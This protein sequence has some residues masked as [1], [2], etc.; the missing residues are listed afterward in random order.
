MYELIFPAQQI[1]PWSPAPWSFTSELRLSK[2]IGTGW[3][4]SQIL[5]KLC[6]ASFTDTSKYWIY[7]E[8][9]N[10]PVPIHN[11]ENA[12]NVAQHRAKYAKLLTHRGYSTVT[13][14]TTTPAVLKLPYPMNICFVC[15]CVFGQQKVVMSLMMQGF[16]LGKYLLNK[17]CRYKNSPHTWPSKWQLQPLHYMVLK[18]RPSS[19]FCDRKYTRAGLG[20]SSGIPLPNPAHQPTHHV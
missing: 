18:K 11:Y 4:V 1:L 15:T 5:A 2:N 17:F 19:P 12:T 20:F 9:Q 6:K 7:L 8:T 14:L 3:Y 13:T 10:L 16:S